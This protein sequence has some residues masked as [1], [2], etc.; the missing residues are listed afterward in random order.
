MKQLGM[1]GRKPQTLR[2]RRCFLRFG[3]SQDG[4]WGQNLSPLDRSKRV[5]SRLQRPMAARLAAHAHASGGDSWPAGPEG[6]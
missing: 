4:Q 2:Y 3:A 5:K 1:A 6:G